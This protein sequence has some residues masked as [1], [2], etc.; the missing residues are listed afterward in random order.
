METAYQNHQQHLVHH[1]QMSRTTESKPRLSKEEVEILEAEFQKNHKPNSTTK[2]AL[3]ESMRV[4]NA[5]IN[6]WFQNRRARE[7]K[8]NNI[9]KYEARQKLEREKG[10]ANGTSKP[11]QAHDRDFVASSAPFPDTTKSSRK[12]VRASKA[13]P[14]RA[15]ADESETASD[16]DGLSD[17]LDYLDAAV[18]CEN[19]DADGDLE[20]H[21]EVGELTDSNSDLR[22]VEN[23]TQSPEG[24][25][26]VDSKDSDYFFGQY[27]HLSKTHSERSQVPYLAEAYGRMSSNSP[28]AQDSGARRNR[29]PPPLA[30]SGARSYSNGVPKTAIELGGRGDI[31]SSMRRAASSNGTVRVTKPTSLP[32]S[33]FHDP[34]HEALF[35]LNR[36]PNMSAQRGTIAPPTPD[37]PIVA[38]APQGVSQNVVTSTFR[39][40]NKL[41]DSH[42]ALNDPTLRTPPS[43]PGLLD[44]MFSLNTAFGMSMSDE[45]LNSAHVE[46]YGNSGFSLQNMPVSQPAYL[47]DNAATA[48]SDAPSYTNQ[49]GNTFFE[50]PGWSDASHSSHSSPEDNQP[51]LM[52]MNMTN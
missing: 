1:H 27:H 41:T 45:S 24:H 21:D 44:N 12:I 26:S 25:F 23:A 5:R 9:R 46:S 37:T 18:K 39:L 17:G 10:E 20:Q 13:S 7:K 36:S 35:H 30:I 38:N 50:Y 3:A 29:R 6:N 47:A 34:K 42:N 22:S 49:L 19:V 14:G 40:E 16:R 51:N 52:F 32:R 31:G 15:N 33:P 4:E 11:G 28:S 43:T 8:E 2:K 48:H